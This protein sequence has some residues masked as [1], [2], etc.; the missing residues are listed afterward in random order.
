MFIIGL[1]PSRFQIKRLD[2]LC[3]RWVAVSGG[4]CGYLRGLCPWRL[5]AIPASK[6]EEKIIPLCWIN[7]LQFSGCRCIAL[8]IRFAIRV[9]SWKQS[10]VN[11]FIIYLICGKRERLDAHKPSYNFRARRG[12]QGS[13]VIDVIVAFQVE[14]TDWERVADFDFFRLFAFHFRSV[15]DEL[16]QHCVLVF[17]DLK[18]HFEKIQP[19]VF[20]YLTSKKYP[21]TA[22]PSRLDAAF[23]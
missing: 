18:L 10:I 16:V 7:K 21:K 19:A 8:F 5:F 17:N 2:R 3:V 20:L 12:G 15:S 14:N 13:L 9:E 23:S 22:R 11:F 6:N 1:L 4:N